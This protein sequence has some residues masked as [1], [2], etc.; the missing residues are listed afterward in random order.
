M[1]AITVWN[2]G[3]PIAVG[4]RDRI[5]ER[6]YRGTEARRTTPGSGLGLYIARKIA[7][8]H[9]GD[10]ALLD[11]RPDEVG[12]RLTLPFSTD[13]VTGAEREL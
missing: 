3:P 1:A 10:L 7:R 6:F 8:A 11:E 5:F 4:E 2:A 9:G 13:E 12:F